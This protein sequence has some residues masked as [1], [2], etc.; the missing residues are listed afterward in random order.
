[1]IREQKI[2]RRLLLRGLGGVALALPILE[3]W[4]KNAKADSLPTPEPF[5]IFF[6]QACGVATAQVTQ[7]AGIEP[8]RFWPRE[9]GALTE[10]TVRER[11]L[12]ELTT[13]LPRTLLVGVNKNNY[14]D[15]ADPHAVGA[16]QGL[17]GRGPTRATSG[18]AGRTEADGES[19]DHRIGRELNP[20]GR[21]SLYLYT[22][23]DGGWLG[24]ACISYRASGQRRAAI[25]NPWTAY[26]MLTGGTGGL[27]PEMAEQVSRGQKS[28]ND[29]VR[30]QL[31]ELLAH[32]ATSAADKQRL[33]MHLTSVRELEVALSC[34]LSDDRASRLESGSSVFN[35]TEHD[36]IVLN[37][38]LHCE[39][40]ALA[41]ACGYT[42][43]V[44]I[45]VGEGNAGLLRFRN[46]ETGQLMDNYH[47]VSH[48]VR[49]DAGQA[50]AI[51]GSDVLHHYVDRYHAQMFRHL[52]D[53]LDAHALPTGG[54]LL[55]HGM[56]IWLNDNAN[57]PAHSLKNVP[58]LICGS[59]NGYLKQGQYIQ[60]SGYEN[61]CQVLNTIGAAVGLK[62]AN[63]N[64]L[65][66]FGDPELA[67]GQRSE[68]LA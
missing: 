41:V 38:N 39:V 48:R 62:S 67:Q 56:A 24:G 29:L 6:R 45:Q 4:P 21:D 46:P 32:P 25:R 9:L 12:D 60:L 64:A 50:D 1:M 63:G 35:S 53:A 8:E 68:L 65:E 23:P 13:Y 40:A 51:T 47:F 14:T 43:S 22:G 28:V 36:D 27:T 55:D 2:S 37:T 57:G 16:Q 52:L 11:A 58:Y 5:A 34:R 44:C 19:L 42:R 59:A 10:D 61:L 15:Y 33:D 66:D 49:A 3:S 54:T 31:Q 18:K 30:G 17:T 7:T 26:Q 20:G